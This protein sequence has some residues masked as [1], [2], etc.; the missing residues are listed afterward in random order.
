MP[1]QYF[2]VPHAPK[3]Y[4]N[5]SASE[6]QLAVKNALRYFDPKF[7]A[8]LKPEFENELE[9][10]GHIYMYR[11]RPNLAIKAYPVQLY[12]SKII[13]SACMMHQIMNNLGKVNDLYMTR[14]HFTSTCTTVINTVITI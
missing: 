5:L 9:T 7:H 2:S 6:A 14:R 8:V 10:Y 3:R 1:K 13:Q 4:H 12:P 11:F